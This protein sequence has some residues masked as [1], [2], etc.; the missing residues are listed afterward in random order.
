M[1]KRKKEPVVEPEMTPA[2]YAAALRAN[3]IEYIVCI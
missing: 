2:E 3:A 1:F